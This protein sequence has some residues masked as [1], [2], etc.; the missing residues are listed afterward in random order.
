L[1]GDQQIYWCP[2]QLRSL[3][4]EINYFEKLS[5]KGD[6]LDYVISIPF[7][8]MN[9]LNKKAFPVVVHTQWKVFSITLRF[10][11]GFSCNL[12]SM[13]ILHSKL[14]AI[15]HGVQL[16]REGGIFKLKIHSDKEEAIL[17]TVDGCEEEHG[18]F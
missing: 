6:P 9:A 13:G 7:L 10:L 3:T 11:G 2:K 8:R 1:L 16:A 12:G 17:L 4:H 18:C 14:W 15:L 5:F